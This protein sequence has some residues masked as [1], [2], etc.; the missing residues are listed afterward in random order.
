MNGYENVLEYEIQT[1]IASNDAIVEKL[2]THKN[3]KSGQYTQYI[4]NVI[5]NCWHNNKQNKKKHL[6]YCTQCI[7]WCAI[8]LMRLI[9]QDVCDWTAAAAA[10]GCVTVTSHK[11]TSNHFPWKFHWKRTYINDRLI[12]PLSAA[13]KSRNLFILLQRRMFCFVFLLLRGCSCFGSFLFFARCVSIKIDWLVFKTHT[14]SIMMKR[15]IHK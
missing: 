12:F 11:S 14:R 7:D 2:L 5:V 4:W 9:Q 10:V 1:T 3:I 15:M 6:N 8:V 13:N